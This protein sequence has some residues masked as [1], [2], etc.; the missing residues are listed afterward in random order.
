MENLEPAFGRFS[1]V[2]QLSKTPSSKK[3][4]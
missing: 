3:L 4:C 2:M 1:R